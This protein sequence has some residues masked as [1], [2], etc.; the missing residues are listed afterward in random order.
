MPDFLRATVPPEAHGLPGSCY[1]RESVLARER[2]RIFWRRWIAAGRSSEIP[3]PGD[4]LAVTLGDE[5]VLMV[6]GTDGA[7]R[8]FYNVCRHRGARLCGEPAGR[9]PGRVQCPYH[10]WT[11]SLDGRLVAAPRTD[12]LDR[13]E[14]TNYPL[15]EVALTDWGGFLFLNLAPTPE[16]FE[17]ALAGLARR[18]D[19]WGLP[20]LSAARRIEYEVRANWKLIVENYSEC[21][22]C[23]RV[24]PALARISPPDSGRN[25]L[26]AGPVLGGYMLLNHRGGSMT[27]S[28]RTA[29]PPLPG[30]LGEERNRVYYYLVF[31]NLL[32]S[33]HP[34]YVMAHFLWPEGPRRTR[35]V[36]EWYFD[37]ATMASPGFDASDATDFWDMT[38]RQDWHVCELTQLGVASRAFSPGPYTDAEGLLWAFDQEYR[39][40]MAEPDGCGAG[41][42]G[43]G[44]PL[45]E[46][47]AAVD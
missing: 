44:T 37:P 21:Y 34:D 18:F 6:R 38:N 28:G 39:R 40:A 41:Q 17:Q 5:S 1:T 27:T 24:H 23:P 7:A 8:A 26:L 29:R 11:Y 25:D 20:G 2:E 46:R 13:F 31:P 16:P 4:F 9:F 45:A 42:A 12:G 15:R 36:C 43:D 19:A 47:S 30:V 33:L 32:L 14:R 35:V 3:A 22:H 10:A